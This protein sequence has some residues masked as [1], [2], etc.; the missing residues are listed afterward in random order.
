MVLASE[1]TFA[2]TDAMTLS[3][4]KFSAVACGPSTRLVAGGSDLRQ[5]GVGGTSWRSE[6]GRQRETVK[7]HVLAGEPEGNCIISIPFGSGVGSKLADFCITASV[8]PRQY[9]LVRGAS[10]AWCRTSED[11]RK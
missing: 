11:P 4:T 1:R 10:E 6:G 3:A 9:V 8:V 2:Y 7:R 5:R